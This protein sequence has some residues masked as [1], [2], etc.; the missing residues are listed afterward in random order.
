M[1][2]LLIE[3]T[4][5]AAYRRAS[6]LYGIGAALDRELTER[7]QAGRVWLCAITDGTN[8]VRWIEVEAPHLPPDHPMAADVIESHVEREAGRFAIETR[9]EDLAEASPLRIE[10][11]L[12]D[13]A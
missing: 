13:A 1:G 8:G 12:A 2:R 4:E 5:R 3:I 9:L 11:Y 7:E 6:S 10:L